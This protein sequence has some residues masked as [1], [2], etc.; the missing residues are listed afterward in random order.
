[1]NSLGVYLLVSLF[2]VVSTMFEFAVVLLLQQVPEWKAARKVNYIRQKQK[3]LNKENFK[4]KLKQNEDVSNQKGISSDMWQDGKG[5]N[6][7]NA[8]KVDT[9]KIDISALITFSILYIL[10]NLTYWFYFN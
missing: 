1:M 6:L 2:F 4:A 9:H 5:E 3:R 8:N 10:F 7:A